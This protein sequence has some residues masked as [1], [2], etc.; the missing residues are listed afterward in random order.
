M[1]GMNKSILANFLMEINSGHPNNASPTEVLKP[2]SV[3]SKAKSLEHDHRILRTGT[4]MDRKMKLG[5]FRALI[6]TK[7]GR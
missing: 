7:L 6:G 1:T 5:A 3:I 2:I 4:I